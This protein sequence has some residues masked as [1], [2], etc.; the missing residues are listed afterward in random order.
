M[1]MFG[2]RKQW[3]GSSCIVGGGASKLRGF[4]LAV[5]V[6]RV[7]GF[8]GVGLVFLFGSLEIDAEGKAQVRAVAGFEPSWASLSAYEA[9]EWFRD[10]K[11]GIYA[12]WGVY[13]ATGGTRNT[14]WYSRNMYDP[15][16]RNYREHVKNHGSVDEFGYKDLI[17][18]FSGELFDAQEWVSLYLEAGARFAGPVAEHGDGFAMWATDL[19]PWN[20]GDMGPKRDVVGE[21]AKA[22]KKAGMKFLTSFHHHWRWGWYPT[23]DQET[24]CADPNFAS[25]YGRKLPS[26]AWGTRG[27]KG[28]RV[29]VMRPVPLPDEAFN[30]SWLSHVK[31]VI[32]RYRPDM[33]WFDNRMEII[34]ESKRLEMLAYFYNQG[35]EWGSDV[36]LTYKRPDLREGVATIDLERARMPGIYPDPW[37]TDSSIASSSW[38][39]AEDLEY[40][41]SNRLIDDLVDI[42]SKNGCLLLNLAPAPDG[43]IPKPQQDRLRE[44]GAWLRIHGEAI[45][46]TRPWMVFGEGPTITEQGHLAD[47][48]FKG[49]DARDIRFTCSKDR[50]RLYVI[51]LGWPHAGRVEIGSM[52]K[53]SG[54]VVAARWL[55]NGESLDFYLD[56]E[57]L[58]LNLPAKPIGSHAHVVVLEG[59][60]LW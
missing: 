27:A 56:D 39:Y 1:V 20:A 44:M 18:H 13:S 11:F 50:K 3:A 52:G 7:V 53:R 38:S 54:N 10:A 49:F 41:S 9:P 22:V 55:S 29:D 16:H 28:E 34:E 24:D 37:L 19:T 17:P 43:T 59:K 21:M 32:D 47:L 26:T 36:V 12:H 60:A 30:V 45:Y 23:W 46:G 8:V 15:N 58:V 40:Y 35:R 48:K 2:F 14:D 6:R 51:L 25:L 4:L 5:S 31:E 57:R 42:V 33:L